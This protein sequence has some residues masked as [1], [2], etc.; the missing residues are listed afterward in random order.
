MA[1][2]P[3]TTAGV[4]AKQSEL[5]ALSQAA[6]DN[7][8]LSLV[9]NFKAWITDNF[10]LTVQE[11]NFLNSANDDFLRK[12]SSIIFVAT[13]NRIPF[14]F[15]KSM[16]VTAAKRFETQAKFDFRYTWGGNLDNSDFLKLNIVYL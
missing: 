7:Q 4:A 8:S 5:F 16:V 2:Q 10:E 13:R 15:T 1:K 11:Q 14:D 12:L 6:L 3:L 9:T